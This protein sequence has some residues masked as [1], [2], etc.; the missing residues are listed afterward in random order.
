[1]TFKNMTVLLVG[2]SV[3]YEWKSR[4]LDSPWKIYMRICARI[5]TARRKIASTQQFIKDSTLYMGKQAGP[6]AQ[7]VLRLGVSFLFMFT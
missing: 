6:E 1:M 2:D 4:F 7:T 5:K 3:L